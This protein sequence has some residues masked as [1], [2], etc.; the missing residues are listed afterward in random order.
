MLRMDLSKP[1]TCAKASEAGKQ[2]EHAC[3]SRRARF[4]A[5]S[6]G[7]SGS[8]RRAT[9]WGGA[10]TTAPVNGV[11]KASPTLIAALPAPSAARSAACAG[12]SSTPPI[13]E[14]RAPLASCGAASPPASAT[15]CNPLPA[16]S[17]GAAL[18]ARLNTGGVTQAAPL[19]ARRAGAGGPL[20]LGSLQNARQPTGSACS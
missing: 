10:C 18:Y 17:G 19:A 15:L 2:G 16:L 9:P 13:R 3:D 5:G 11:I 6:V 1:R 20:C 14:L 4:C 8:A 12:Q 7:P